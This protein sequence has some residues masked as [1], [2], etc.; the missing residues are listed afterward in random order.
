MQP[1]LRRVAPVLLNPLL[2][3]RTDGLQHVMCPNIGQERT[4]NNKICIS[5][6]IHGGPKT[7]RELKLERCIGVSAACLSDYCRIIE[8][9]HGRRHRWFWGTMSP[10]L[11]RD[12]GDREGQEKIEILGYCTAIWCMSGWWATSLLT[13]IEVWNLKFDCCWSIQL[14]RQLL[15]GASA[16]YDVWKHI[17]APHVGS[18]GWMI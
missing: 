8:P 3:W 7:R 2:D 10:P 4:K 14:R 11:T 16:V 13:V 12:A 1:T 17:C 15:K 5:Q 6:M 18:D 9:P